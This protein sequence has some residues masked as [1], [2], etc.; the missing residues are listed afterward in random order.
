[1]KNILFRILPLLAVV[2][3]AVSCSKDDGS[4]SPAAPDNNTSVVAPESDKSV[5]TVEPVAVRDNVPSIPFSITVNKDNGESL[6][7]ATITSES[8]IAQL[9]EA[10]DQLVISCSSK[11][12]SGTLKLVSG[13]GTGSAT[14][15][16]NLEGADVENI[17]TDDPEL[18]ATLINETHGNKGEPLKSF[19]YQTFTL[20][21]AFQKYGY[22]TNTFHFSERDN[23]K[24]VQKTS[25]IV[26]DIPYS[27]AIL[28]TSSYSD[29]IPRSTKEVAANCVLA[30]PDGLYVRS[31]ELG[32]SQRQVKLGDSKV[33]VH[34]VTRTSTTTPIPPYC[35]K[36]IFSVGTNK[37]VYIASKNFCYYDGNYQFAESDISSYTVENSIEKVNTN[38]EGY[39]GVIEHFDWG[40][41]DCPTQTSPCADFV[42]WGWHMSNDHKWRTLT[43]DEWAY[44]LGVVDGDEN[45]NSGAYRANALELRAQKKIDGH[46]CLVVLPDACRGVDIENTDV[47]T[48]RNYG[49]AILPYVG[50]RWD[51]S[52]LIYSAGWDGCYCTHTKGG[53]YSTPYYVYFGTSFGN[54]I[55]VKPMASAEIQGC[56]VRLVRDVE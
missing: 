28:E 45:F 53:K 4:D 47:E 13:E 50:S 35:V 48:L 16:G 7:K 49:A 41:G 12:I 56:S 19:L 36:G 51:K 42:D 39:T 17:A 43:A 40:T 25:F 21:E 20:T 37:R 31:E 14:F 32:I 1:M 5:E 54:N 10:D 55:Y 6:S 15:E 34:R 11:D 3:F 46:W 9:F 26:F 52:G 33:V 38:Y 30:I 22:L 44:L 2:L 24:L 18:T 23:V 29:F 27:G 8:N